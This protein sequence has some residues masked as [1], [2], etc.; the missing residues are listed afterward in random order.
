MSKQ[1]NINWIHQV[2]FHCNKLKVTFSSK[3]VTNYNS[4][5][6]SELA[7][8]DRRNKDW[9]QAMCYRNSVNISGKKWRGK[10][11]NHLTQHKIRKTRES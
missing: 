3:A 10:M 4:G 11:G 5:S 6:Q 1:Q 2:A 7:K 9:A 8:L